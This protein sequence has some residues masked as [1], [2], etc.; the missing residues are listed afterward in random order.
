MPPMHVTRL[1]A[2]L[3]VVAGALAIVAGF[4]AVA[5]YDV[6]EAASAAFD[7]AFGSAF[8]VLSGTL[9]RATP[10]LLLGVAVAVAFRAGVLNIGAEGQF[11]SGAAAAVA[12][13][14][15]ASPGTPGPVL[16]LS[17]LAA[18]AAAGLAWAGIAAWLKARFRVTEVVSTLLLNFV[19]INLV[20]YLVRG[21]LQEP[22]Y[23]YP[24]SPT[25][26]DVARLPLLFDGHRLHLGFLISLAVAVGA[27]WV[28]SRTAAGFR[29]RL[30][31]LSPRAA[32][33]AGLVPVERVQAKALL[34]SGAI[35]GVAGFCEVTGVTYRLFEGLS[36]GYGYTAIAV[37]LLGNLNPIGIIASATLFGALG[38]GADAM[39]RNA[40]IPAEFASVVAALIVLGVLAVPVLQSAVFRRPIGES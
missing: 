17:E 30:A 13:G 31:G 39:Q 5:G 10:L 2:Q 36:P 6:S 23:T 35:A 21:P 40:G 27:W 26:G 34:V 12:V 16:V 22:T 32:A 8:A 9:K 1:G 11:L 3:L 7:G 19:A 38:S 15:Y 37:A 14:L 24:Q 20:G 29:L 18:A 28:F 33:S 4:V 25:I